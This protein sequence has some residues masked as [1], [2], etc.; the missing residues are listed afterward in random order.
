M[1]FSKLDGKGIDLSSNVLT[2]F[3]STG[4]DDNATGSAITIA[5][6]NSVEINDRFLKLSGTGP[7]LR[8]D[9][10]D[11]STTDNVIYYQNTDTT[12]I[13]YIG[14][15]AETMKF[16]VSDGTERVSL[17]TAGLQLLGEGTGLYFQT[18]ST[19]APYI[20]T[21]DTYGTNSLEIDSDNGIT[22]A[23][24]AND[25]GTGF[26]Q[27]YNRATDND[28]NVP[29]KIDAD[30]QIEFRV[31]G[32]SSPDVGTQ[33]RI[34]NVD[35]RGAQDALILQANYD[36]DVGLKWLNNVSNEDWKLYIDGAGDDA[37]V[38]T[39]TGNSMFL[40]VTQDNGTTLIGKH[41]TATERAKLRAEID[42]MLGADSY[43]VRNANTEPQLHQANGGCSAF[44]C[45]QNSTITIASIQA[46]R[47]RQFELMEPGGSNSYTSAVSVGG[48]TTPSAATNAT[49]SGVAGR[50]YAAN[51]PMGFV[52]EGDHESAISLAA[53]GRYFGFKSTRY[54]PSTVRVFPINGN[55]TVNMYINK[56]INSG[57]PEYS[58]TAQAYHVTSQEL[59]NHTGDNAYD[60]V[61][62]IVG[63]LAVCTTVGTTG[64]RM[65]LKP[66]S[67]F[68]V[69]ADSSAPANGTPK[70]IFSYSDATNVDNSLYYH[71]DEPVFLS[72]IGDGSGGDAVNG[73]PLAM[74]GDTYIIPHNLN[75]YSLAAFYGDT[76]VGVTYWNYTNSTW[77]THKTHSLAGTFTDPDVLNVGDVDAGGT[78]ELNTIDRPIIIHADRPFGLKVNDDSSTEYEPFGYLA[79][80]AHEHFTN[81][82]Y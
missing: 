45:L 37:L 19:P 17:T 1:A 35:D 58:F 25:N 12:E 26:F 68:M 62:E 30:N 4:I 29:F 2:S 40:S 27:V 10:G 72:Q 38:L 75:G 5:S 79:R 48:D 36:R 39:D 20:K 63:G 49:F 34:I 47:L 76:T 32:V 15:D 81:H 24:E 69:N 7:A 43:I 61:I 13:L 9:K 70:T 64:D 14:R 60:V 42:G 57:S 3:A 16:R 41:S 44:V 65:M 66:A 18:S 8:V 59:T 53:A 80:Y 31:S 67:R 21:S 78:G 6:D 11:G 28:T 33:V 74:L 52:A 54:Q 55:V 73:T 56:G 77:T 71:Y 50:I 22:M 46:F 51:R 82:G 23:F